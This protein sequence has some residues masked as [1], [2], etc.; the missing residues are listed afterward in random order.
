[1]AVGGMVER[2]GG[3]FLICSD[4]SS[5]EMVERAGGEK[6]N[7]KREIISDIWGKRGATYGE[8]G[9]VSCWRCLFPG[10]SRAPLL[11]WP[12]LAAVPRAA[13]H[14]AL[15][16]S[17]Q[18]PLLSTPPV[19]LRPIPTPPLQRHVRRAVAAAQ[20]PAAPRAPR[21]AARWMLRWMFSIKM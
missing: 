4:H 6:K 8:N 15:P 2:A 11:A 10:C 7:E 5:R 16:S 3:V 19:A 20:P 13:L 21:R 1:M 17:P 12:L 18:P 14:S 9:G